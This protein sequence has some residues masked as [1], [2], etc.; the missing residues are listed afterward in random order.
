[1]SDI[2]HGEQIP[3]GI[4]TTLISAETVV[5]EGVQLF[6]QRWC[7]DLV[8]NL[9]Q[10]SAWICRVLKMVAGV[11]QKAESLLERARPTPVP[12]AGAWRTVTAS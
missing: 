10:G 12:K 11:R 7:R 2:C 8:N 4:L 9:D 3:C 6:Q 1:M 5:A